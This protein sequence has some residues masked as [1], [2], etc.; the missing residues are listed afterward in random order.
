MNLYGL[1]LSALLNAQQNLQTTGHNINNSAIEGYSRQTVLSQTQGA[2][3]TGA[4]YI[5][6]GIQTVTIQRAY[7]QFLNQQLMSS[8][9]KH[10]EYVSYG[11]QIAQL[12]NLFSDRESGISPALQEFFGALQ[13]VA[14]SPDD[15][16][17]RQ[18]L[19]GRA[20][21]VATQLKETDTFIEN[22]RSN[23]NTQIGTLTHQINSYVERIHDLNGQITKAQAATPNHSPNDLLDQRD[24]LL[25]E[26]NE[27]VE[28]KSFEQDGRLNLTLSNGQ[29]LLS[30]STIHELR[31]IPSTNDPSR[32][33]LAYQIQGQE[34]TQWVE[35]DDATIQGGELGGVL[36]YRAQTLDAAQNALGRLALGIGQS[37]NDGH[38]QGVDLDGETGADMF[39]F[40][41][42]QGI[43]LSSTGHPQ[44]LPQLSVKLKDASAL[45]LRDYR[46]EAQHDA[47]GN[48]KGLAFFDAQSGALIPAQKNSDGNESYYLID[49]LKVTLPD[50]DIPLDAQW[51]LQPTRRAAAGFGVD[52]NDPAK[53][54]AG[55]PGAG[56]AN[57]DNALALA[58]LQNQQI[59]GQGNLNFNDAFGQLV[60]RIAVQTQENTA[61]AKAQENLVQQ[62][63]AAQQRVS[64]VNL[65][66]EYF[67]LEQYVEQFRAASKLIDVGTAMF[68]TL[69]SLRP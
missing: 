64:G 69:L 51:S 66:E 14:S 34:G 42:G 2:N 63:F 27:L 13:A 32:H 38:R 50:G 67:L 55:A 40:D 68:D 39:Y 3:A 12:N 28:V 54:A 35:M 33:V 19:L 22:Q 60:N 8:K 21:N 57:G 30:G 43:P 20:Q 53:I 17:A 41:V 1:G 15:A 49:G 10:T 52:L 9:G 56:P 7:D 4:G 5:G 18:E 61:A 45:A 29:L 65:N 26:L 37:I 31:A 6:R 46:I 58:A 23:L 11:N 47:E 36:R 16:A 48:F 25:M 44:G 62:N 24:Q 59:L